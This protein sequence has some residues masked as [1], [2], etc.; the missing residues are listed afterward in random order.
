MSMKK[1]MREF[2]RLPQAEQKCRLCE[3]KSPVVQCKPKP[4]TH[5]ELVNLCNRFSK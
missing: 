5:K 4:A 3:A 1:L 2:D